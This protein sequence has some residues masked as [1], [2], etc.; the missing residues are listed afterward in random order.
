MV[1]GRTVKL[2]SVNC[3]EICYTTY[4]CHDIEHETRLRKIK[5]LPT[6][7]LSDVETNHKFYIQ[8]NIHT[9]WYFNLATYMVNIP[10]SYTYTVIA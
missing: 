8:Y 6:F 5:I 4:Y 2:K 3:M 1:S 9:I 7:N 10:V